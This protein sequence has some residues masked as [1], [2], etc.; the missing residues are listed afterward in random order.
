M[1]RNFS[2]ASCTVHFPGLVLRFCP[3]YVAKISSVP[4]RAQSPFATAYCVG[5]RAFECVVKL[6]EPELGN[7]L[8]LFYPFD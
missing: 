7:R 6:S 5:P 2:R 4:K 8:V 1:R 3:S